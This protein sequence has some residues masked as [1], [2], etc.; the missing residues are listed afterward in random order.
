MAPGLRQA[1]EAPLRPQG[2]VQL[3]ALPG[4]ATSHSDKPAMRMRGLEPPRGSWRG[5]GGWSRVVRSG[6]AMRFQCG[7]LR[8]RRMAA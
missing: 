1:L 4:S 2:E 7:P 8:S 5:G 3:A 6:F